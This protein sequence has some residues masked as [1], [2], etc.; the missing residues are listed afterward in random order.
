MRGRWG[1][2]ELP[3]VAEMRWCI[4]TCASDTGWYDSFG[5]GH[6]WGWYWRWDWECALFMYEW[7]QWT[8]PPIS[9]SGGHQRDL[10][11]CCVSEFD[12][13][14]LFLRRVSV[15]RLIAIWQRPE[16]VCDNVY[17]K[18]PGLAPYRVFKHYISTIFLYVYRQSFFESPSDLSE[19]FASRCFSHKTQP[20]FIE[21][22]I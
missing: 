10:S 17:S 19:T 15:W 18:T 12:A 13:V 20:G 11:L 22:P 21:K 14:Q 5:D 9:K 2:T 8:S 16:S 1:E 3:A 4:L 7:R 6:F